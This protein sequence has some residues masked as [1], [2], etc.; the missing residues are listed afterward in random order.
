MS[1]LVKTGRV[2]KATK[3]VRVDV[4]GEKPRWTQW[5]NRRTHDLSR[6]PTYAAWQRMKSECRGSPGALYGPWWSFEGFYRDM[7][8]KPEWGVLRRRDASQP[9]GPGNACWCR[10]DP[11]TRKAIIPPLDDKNEQEGE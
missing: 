8:P 6:T 11:K 5:P 2:V 4:S 7:G 9:W 10:L 1:R 3:R